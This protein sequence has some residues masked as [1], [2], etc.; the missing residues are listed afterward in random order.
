M[1]VVVI[2]V[3]TVIMNGPDPITVAINRIAV[4]RV[5]EAP[6]WISISVCGIGVSVRSVRP[7]SEPVGRIAPPVI[8]AVM[9]VA[10]VVMAVVI[11]AVITVPVVMVM[12]RLHWGGKQYG[13]G[14]PKDEV[15]TH[16]PSFTAAETTRLFP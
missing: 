2:P 12:V 8:A 4:A 5:T 9:M 14:R 11:M 7:I 3:G 10:V 16:R 13:R 1:V 6:R 15:P